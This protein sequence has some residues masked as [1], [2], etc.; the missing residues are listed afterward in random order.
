[1]IY[2]YLHF[3]QCNLIA[4]ISMFYSPDYLESAC[5][6]VNFMCKRKMSTSQYIKWGINYLMSIFNPMFRFE[7]D[8]RM[9]WILNLKIN[10]SITN[11]NEMY[12]E[13]QVVI[14]IWSLQYETVIFQGKHVNCYSSS[15]QAW[16]VVDWSS[17]TL[18]LHQA[19]IMPKQT[20]FFSTLLLKYLPF[21]Y[22]HFWANSQHGIL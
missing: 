10:F 20:V 5:A 13:W 16:M 12:L 22:L 7:C 2:L 8:K 14:T 15:Y 17:V 4:L 6:K 21:L 9:K 18:K 1:M 3:P 19:M 11:L